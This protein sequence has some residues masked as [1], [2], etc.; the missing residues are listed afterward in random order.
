MFVA[1]PVASACGWLPNYLLLFRFAPVF[2][3]GAQ[4]W[5]RYYNSN[6]TL[7]L[8]AVA[9]SNLLAHNLATALF[10]YI[11]F[12]EGIPT[13]NEPFSLLFKIYI[14]FFSCVRVSQWCFEFFIAF[15]LGK[16]WKWGPKF[17]LRD[18]LTYHPAFYY[19]VSVY[20]LVAR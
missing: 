6:F 7:H 18:Q 9:G 11:M 1:R 13:A 19:F 3:R 10:V 16:T 4:S 2:L 20:N 17:G 8:Q 14:G 5:R 12:T 15:G